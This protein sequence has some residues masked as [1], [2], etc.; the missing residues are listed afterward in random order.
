MQLGRHS[1]G[2][3]Y[4]GPAP[5]AV[6]QPSCNR[7]SRPAA[8]KPPKPLKPPLGCICMRPNLEA[9]LLCPRRPGPHEGA[10]G[11]QIASSSR[12]PASG[13]SISHARDGAKWRP[14]ESKHSLAARR[15][16]SARI[17][18]RR[19]RWLA[20]CELCAASDGELEGAVAASSPPADCRP[21][22]CA[23]TKR[24]WR[25]AIALKAH[26]ACQLTSQPARPLA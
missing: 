24:R 17:G 11:R 22:R 2:R 4:C 15:P 20:C 6:V 7:G 14:R 5:A 18:R 21:A 8:P 23:K 16:L 10:A 26:W 3:L 19:R 25:H 12:P 9:V 1:A 13:G